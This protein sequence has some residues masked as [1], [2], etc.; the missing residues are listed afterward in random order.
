MLFAFTHSPEETELFAEQVAEKIR[1]GAVIACKGGLGAGK[2]AFA[3]GLARG[4]GLSDDVFSP[5]F[6]LVHEYTGGAVPLY[7]FDLYR[8]NDFDSLYSTGF[9]DYLDQVGIAFIEWSE[10]VSDYL[11][12]GHLTLTIEH[13]GENERAITLEGDGF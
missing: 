12:D 8:I 4:L 13:M 10:Q 5:T 6:A 9:F 3:R 11:P 1:P 2:T 7:H